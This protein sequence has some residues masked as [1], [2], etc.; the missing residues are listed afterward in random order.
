M[1]VYVMAFVLLTV[2]LGIL[3][4]F[5]LRV[6]YRRGEIGVRMAMGADKGSIRRCMLIEGLCLAVMAMLP[7]LVIYFNMLYAEILDTWRLPFSASRVAIA[8]TASFVII[9][10]FII[11]GT[12]LPANRAANITPVEALRTDN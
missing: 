5:W 10:C 7:A 9:A 11:I 6:H 1:M 4:T 2:F 12:L 3:G 8:F